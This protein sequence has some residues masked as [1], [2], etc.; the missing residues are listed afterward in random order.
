MKSYTITKNEN[1]FYV[2]PEDW[3]SYLYTEKVD[4]LE[5]AASMAAIIRNREIPEGSLNKFSKTTELDRTK[6][7]SSVTNELLGEYRFDENSLSSKN[8][9]FKEIVKSAL[10]SYKFYNPTN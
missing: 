8:A 10:N 5:T 1:K 7:Y 2:S 9:G 4:I 6:I 3:K